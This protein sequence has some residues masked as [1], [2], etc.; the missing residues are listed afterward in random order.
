MLT[1]INYESINLNHIPNNIHTKN[2]NAVLFFVFCVQK[3]EVLFVLSFSSIVLHVNH[4]ISM[5]NPNKRVI[6]DHH[7][8]NT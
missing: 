6:F 2:T 1:R 7:L 8:N 4:L 5:E 3:L